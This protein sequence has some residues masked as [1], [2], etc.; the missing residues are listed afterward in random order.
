M[1]FKNILILYKRSAYKIYF[2]DN[3]RSL[4]PQDKSIGRHELS[5]FQDAHHQ[6]YETLR[7]VTRILLTH[8][9]RFT[10]C[11]RGHDINFAPYDLIITVGGDGTFLEAARKV[12]KQVMLGVNSAPD[13]SVGRYCIATVK[14][15]ERILSSIITNRYKTADMQRLELTI[16][17]MKKPALILNDVLACHSNPAALFRYYLNVRGKKEEQRS[18]GIWISTAS[19]S[20]GAIHSAG[21]KLLKP[22]ERKMQ[23]IPRELYLGKNKSYHLKGNILSNKDEITITSLTRKAMI[24]FDGAH[25]RFPFD[26]GSV[27]KVRLSSSPIRTIKI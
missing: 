6:H 21:G 26:Y 16:D 13:H 14:N 8:G 19:G 24:Y 18:S 22:F 3:K 17:G 4:F 12:K 15:F 1:K 10:E 25:H 5:Q 9:I 2:L 7:S 27:A 23:Y 20:S 11:Y